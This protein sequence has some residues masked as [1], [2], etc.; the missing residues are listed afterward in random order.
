M[1]AVLITQFDLITHFPNNP[2][3][4]EQLKKTDGIEMFLPN[5]FLFELSKSSEQLASIQEILR[6]DNTSSYQILYF[7]HK[8]VS[9]IRH[10]VEKD[11]AKT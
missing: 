6:R 4:I 3:Y 8:P 5:S 2:A 1:Y 7:E 10:K 9:F 11:A